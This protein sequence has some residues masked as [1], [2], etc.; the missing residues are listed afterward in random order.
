[1]YI[2]VSGF[3]LHKMIRKIFFWIF[4]QLVISYKIPSGCNPDIVHQYHVIFGR[5]NLQE[6]YQA[7]IKMYIPHVKTDAHELMKLLIQEA[8]EID[9]HKVIGWY[10]R[11][12]AK[13]KIELQYRHFQ[14]AATSGHLKQVKIM[15]DNFLF[16]Q[17]SWFQGAS[18]AVQFKMA[19]MSDSTEREKLGEIKSYLIQETAIRIEKM[20]EQ[21]KREKDPIYKAE[22]EE[23]ERLEKENDYKNEQDNFWQKAMSIFD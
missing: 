22:Q 9:K 13:G 3:L 20:K 5:D 16:N 14:I 1:M 11:D 2:H 21:L 18:N 4:F 23:K 17:Y 6:C 19:K 7:I 15:A 10:M 8:F 12:L